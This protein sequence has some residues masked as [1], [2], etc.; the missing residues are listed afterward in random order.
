MNQLSGV[1]INL[2][3]KRVWKLAFG[4]EYN[5]EKLIRSTL[6]LLRKDELYD[7]AKRH[8]LAV[9]KKMKKEEIAAIITGVLVD[10][11]KVDVQYLLL[12]EFL[13]LLK[14]IIETYKDEFDEEFLDSLQEMPFFD[15]YEVDED[16]ALFL[17]EMGYVVIK[18]KS[19]DEHMALTHFPLNDYFMLNL[20]EIMLKTT[21]NDT[22]LDYLEGLTN[23][24]GCLSIDQFLHIWDKYNEESIKKEDI[25]RF[26]EQMQR[27]GYEFWNEGNY[28]IHEF[29]DH[30]DYL[31]LLEASSKK[32]YYIPTEDEI[33]IYAEHFIDPTSEA[34]K[35]IEDYFKKHREGLTEEEIEE[36]IYN[37]TLALKFDS[38]PSDIFRILDAEGYQI[39]D[40]NAV[41]AFSKVL[42]SAI[43][44][45]R[46]WVNRGATPNELSKHFGKPFM[47]DFPFS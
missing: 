6:L 9:K 11:F 32:P 31:E 45:T 17:I 13:F 14:V 37:V 2:N 46:K 33:Y 44:N 28:I 40:E 18:E 35:K 20:S 15:E 42:A 43:N 30:E 38:Y 36:L 23:L 47:K 1:V 21:V 3:Q 41:M 34:Y 25:K 10:H 7:V 24:Y 19:D 16:D 26:I 22:L 29:L 8:K 27:R 5:E 12:D 4:E 39:E